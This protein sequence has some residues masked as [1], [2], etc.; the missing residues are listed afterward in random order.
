MANQR[1][2][3]RGRDDDRGSY[4][5]GDDR[6]RGRGDDGDDRRFLGGGSY[7]QRQ[8]SDDTSQRG[9]AQGRYEQGRI[10]QG[11]YEQGRYEQGR[12][13]GRHE[14]GRPQDGDHRDRPNAGR[15][16][17]WGDFAQTRE[18]GGF[19]RSRA[20]DG[21]LEGERYRQQGHGQEGLGRHGQR[22]DR[23]GGYGDGGRDGQGS[24]GQ[25]GHRAHW[26]ASDDDRNRGDWESTRFG[27]RGGWARGDQGGGTLRGQREGS[28][29]G[30]AGRY[31][32]HRGNFG[33]GDRGRGRDLEGRGYGD[34][35]AMSGHWDDARM[36]DD[37]AWDGGDRGWSAR[38][39]REPRPYPASREGGGR[40]DREDDQRYRFDVGRRPGGSA[41]HGDDTSPSG[42]IGQ[43]G[44]SA[45][46]YGRFDNDDQ[47]IRLHGGRFKSRDDD[48][49]RYGM[50]LQ[51]GAGRGRNVIDDRDLE[52]RDGTSDRGDW[53]RQV[54]AED[55]R[56]HTRGGEQHRRPDDR[57][58]H[59]R[60]NREN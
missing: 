29:S 46:D 30:D 51:G 25:G 28:W 39:H 7:G 27:D 40:W 59:V 32:E 12:L 13:D 41:W 21:R 20:A 52:D 57:F 49:H 56:W 38:E 47:D 34:E 26:M 31:D 53:G 14:P 33:R 5:G 2:D 50:G 1:W 37:R 55:E 42:G 19:E 10:D 43:Y 35:R 4:R 54:W 24:P 60:Q 9:Y 36:R 22:G 48:D 23:Q 8:F 17:D 44:R 15:G 18:H 11:R 6:F 16:R 45:G 3:H 58:A